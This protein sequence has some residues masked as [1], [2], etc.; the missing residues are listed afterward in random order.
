[1]TEPNPE[2]PYRLRYESLVTGTR[3]EIGFQTNEARFDWALDHKGFRVTD[4]IDPEPE[5]VTPPPTMSDEELRA[6]IRDVS[7]HHIHIEQKP[8]PGSWRAAVGEWI[9]ANANALDAEANRRE[10]DLPELLVEML[11]DVFEIYSVQSPE[12]VKAE[13]E[14]RN[15]YRA[16]LAQMHKLDHR[17]E[18]RQ[19]T[20]IN[21]SAYGA[22]GIGF[23]GTCGVCGLEWSIVG[24]QLYDPASGA[25]IIEDP[26]YFE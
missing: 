3:Y 6:S 12:E 17:H 18:C 19:E 21:V 25:H 1:M 8:R 2:G 9:D 15:R 16:R 13:I 20:M 11:G 5:V 26:H 14:E 10:L 24:G 23:H 7:R 4:Y 22:P